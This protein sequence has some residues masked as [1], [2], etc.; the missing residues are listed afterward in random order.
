[1]CVCV[2]VCVRA[3]VCVRASFRFRAQPGSVLCVNNHLPLLKLRMTF[4]A[5]IPT[6]KNTIKNKQMKK[7]N[8]PNKTNTPQPPTPA[9]TSN[10]T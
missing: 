2:C 5:R 7:I 8:Q 9:P 1:M 4:Q 10:M 6:P 3:R